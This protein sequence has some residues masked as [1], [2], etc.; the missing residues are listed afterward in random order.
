MTTKEIET[1]AYNHLWAKGKYLV[2][3]VAAP[4]EL[5]NKY[6]RERV[7]L[8]MYE[9][10]GIWKCFE[11]K[12]SVSDFRSSAKHSFWGDYGYY[13]LNADIYQAVKDE[14]PNDIGV[15]LVHKP[16]GSKGW[17]ECVKK[18]KKRERLC[19]HESLMFALMQAMSREYKKYRKLKDKESSVKK[20]S[21]KRSKGNENN[22]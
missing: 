6:H 7:D 4:R 18:P 1:I 10:T 22:D 8:L 2:F 16:D 15:W 11:I 12:N 5:V 13:I 17:M 3:E 19:S 21:S 9:S 20:K 14:I